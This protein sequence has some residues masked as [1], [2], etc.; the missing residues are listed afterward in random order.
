MVSHI[1]QG[2]ALVTGASTGIGAVYAERL[3]RRGYDL[4]LVA[5][6]QKRLDAFAAHLADSTHRSVQVV[7][8]DL[9]SKKDLLAVETRLRT[10]TRITMLV[11]NAGFASAAPLLSSDVDEMEAM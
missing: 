9:S 11:N 7:A 10:D 3:A 4:V 1:N 6:N 2:T 5:R 8:A